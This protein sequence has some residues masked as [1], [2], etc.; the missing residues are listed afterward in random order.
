MESEFVRIVVDIKPDGT[1]R[2]KA[3]E[4][5]RCEE[6]DAE[7]IRDRPNGELRML[8]GASHSDPELGVF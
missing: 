4:H 5:H 3:T 8:D 1:A 7:Y 2:H 6:C